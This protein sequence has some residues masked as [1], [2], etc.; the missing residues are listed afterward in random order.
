MGG[1]NAVPI[2]GLVSVEMGALNAEVQETCSAS[3]K[4]SFVT[5]VWAFLTGISVG[6]R[7]VPFNMTH[8]LSE[9]E[10]QTPPDE[11]GMPFWGHA[12]LASASAAWGPIGGSLQYL[13]LGEAVTTS[14]KGW[15]MGFDLSL[16][17]AVGASIP[18]T[19]HSACC[20]TATSGW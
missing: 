14:I 10:T 1:L 16:S 3:G 13:Q 5:S 18:L 15:Q 7:L 20:G 2:R 11:I 19:V 4:T 12:I 17:I 8:F 6:P 9:M